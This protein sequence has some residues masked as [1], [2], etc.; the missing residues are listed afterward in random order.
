M[1]NVSSTAKPETTSACPTWLR[2]SILGCVLK[3][4]RRHWAEEEGWN[5]DAC[6]VASVAGVAGTGGEYCSVALKV[7]N[8]LQRE[9]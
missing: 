4:H 5:D 6:S 7:E 8:R 1:S 3:I 9:V 2:R